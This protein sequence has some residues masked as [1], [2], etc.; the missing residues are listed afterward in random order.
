MTQ[1]MRKQ[2]LPLM[3]G[4]DRSVGRPNSW[5]SR[6]ARTAITTLCVSISAAAWADTETFDLSGFDG[7]SAAEGIHMQ[8]TTGE[9]FKVTAESKDAK[10]LELLDLDVLHGILRAQMDNRPLSRILAEQATVTIRVTMPSLIHVE[11]LKGAKVVA[12]AMSGTTLKVASS[13]GSTLQI[14]EID[15]GKISV[16]VSSGAKTKI[17]G[18]ICISLSADVSGGSSLDM[19][20][21]ACVDAKIN[22]SSGSKASIH[23][24]KSI[25]AGA[26]S[27]ARIRVYGAHEETDIDVSSGGKVDFP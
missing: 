13:S 27:G 19:E 10:Q 20:K 6:L 11:A 15:A 23:A 22:A 1:T 26:S 18:G 9:V 14:N 25:K 21:V 2:A 7:I 16:Q 8:I 24:D 12:D 4:A 17:G 5:L 3:K